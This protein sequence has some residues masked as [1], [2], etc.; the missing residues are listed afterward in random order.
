MSAKNYLADVQGRFPKALKLQ[1]I[2]EDHELWE[3]E[4]YELFLKTRRKMLADSLNDWLEGIVETSAMDGKVTLEDLI[5][6]GENEDLEFKETFRWDVR[7]GTVNKDLENVILKTIAAFANAHGGRLLIGVTDDGDVV[8]LERD[9]KSLGGGG[10]DKF[11]LHL[12]NLVQ[13]SFGQSF[14]ATKVAV[15]FPEVS[16]IEF[17]SIEIK[18]ANKPTFLQVAMKGGPAQ[19]RFY[20]R[21]GNSSPELSLSEAQ[22]Y[23]DERFV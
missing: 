6:E 16:G 14:A 2:P 3:I 21:S 12:T 17:C 9:Y 7:Q 19:E 1:L 8:G 15:T 10:K 11:E 22:A 23:I 13:K 18:A 4:N 20:V 5:A